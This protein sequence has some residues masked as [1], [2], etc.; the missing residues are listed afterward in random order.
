MN[1]AERRRQAR[2]PTQTMQNPFAIPAVLNVGS[3][4]RVAKDTGLKLGELTAWADINREEQRKAFVK[5]FNHKLHEAEDMIGLVNTLIFCKAINMV[6]GYNKSIAKVIDKMED[7]HEYILNK[8]LR[9]SIKEINELC[10]LDLEFDSFWIEDFIA[11]A[12]RLDLVE[13]EAWQKLL[14]ALRYK[15]VKKE[16]YTEI[17]DRSGEHVWDY[18]DTVSKTQAYDVFTGILW[19]KEHYGIKT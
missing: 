18:T 2:T 17:Y 6:W 16:D 14:K 3:I 12:E 11:G 8:G 7:A 19:A 5:E 15:E 13:E 10:G 9:E 1:R 4:D